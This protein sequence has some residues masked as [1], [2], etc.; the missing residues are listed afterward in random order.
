MA[1]NNP[2]S[3]ESQPNQSH[4]N[5]VFNYQ[6]K[7]LLEGMSSVPFENIAKRRKLD[8]SSIDI[9]YLGEGSISEILSYLDVKSL[10]IC[11]SVCKLWYAVIRNNEFVEMH[12]S[13]N[14]GRFH[15]PERYGQSLNSDGI[16]ETYQY[17]SSLNGLLLEKR[18]CSERAKYRILNP[19][20]KEILDI[21]Y[22]NTR[23]HLLCLNMYLDSSTGLYNLASI[24]CDDKG[25][26]FVFRVLDLGRPGNYPCC[27]EHLSWR[28]L[29]ITEMDNI[30]ENGNY[31]FTILG[32][33]VSML[34]VIRVPTA[35][36]TPFTKPE[37]I[38]VDLVQETRAT[39][40]APES[41]LNCRLT[42]QLWQQKPTIL[43]LANDKLSVW[44]LEDYREHKWSDKLLIPLTYLNEYPRLRKVVPGFFHAD[45]E[46]V[47]LYKYTSVCY[48]YKLESKE[49]C[50]VAPSTGK[51]IKVADTLVSLKG[52]RP[53]KI[54]C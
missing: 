43:S 31:R 10:M 42:F 32:S 35:R 20:T 24:S 44:V 14:S 46:D 41:M 34:Y 17:Q 6:S 28:T 4:T 53:E 25:S 16:I 19:S 7:T 29:N 30:N 36:F 48:A 39:C 51:N 54:S 45:G 33:E 11:K 3:N 1:T 5:P 2:Q 12:M 49:F 22:P 8:K 38:C 52:M 40:T 26:K 50:S 9:P 23:E 47:L 37:I 18:I 21:P 13:R 15:F 27:C